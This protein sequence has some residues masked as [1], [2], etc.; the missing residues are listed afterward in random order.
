ML[1]K[2][3]AFYLNLES[4]VNVSMMTTL[5]NF[6]IATLETLNSRLISLPYQVY[7]VIILIYLSTTQQSE[8]HYNSINIHFNI[9]YNT[10]K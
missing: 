7:Y 6:N 10:G 4:T 3:G 2:E 8:R 1:T 9:V 5:N